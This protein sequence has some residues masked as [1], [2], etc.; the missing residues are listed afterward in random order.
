MAIKET[1]TTIRTYYSLM[2]KYYTESISNYNKEKSQLEDKLNNKY[3]SL[4]DNKQI[5]KD[6]FKIDLDKYEEFTKC[7][8]I[9]GSLHKLAKGLFINRNNNYELVSDLYDL[10]TFANIQKQIVEIDNNISFQQKLV[11]LTL[12]EYIEILRIFYTEVHKQMIMN[13]CGYSFS[14]SIGWICINR[15]KLNRNRPR[16]DYAKTKKREAELRAQG[17]RIYNKEEADWCLR[18]GI[19]YKAEDKRVFQDIEY[20]YEI[21]LIHSKLPNAS[22]IKFEISDYRHKDLRGKTNDNLI[23]LCNNSV[24]EICKLPIDLRTKL[25]IADK[26]NKILYTNFIR[27]EAQTSI[28]F[29]KAN[30]KD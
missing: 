7:V 11:N 13:G 10:F 20:V 22:K 15:I 19:E 8:Y 1:P 21:P 29:T 24:E 6:N 23:E 2:K 14:S 16:I 27:N 28:A 3:Q 18:N 25:N 12:K 17:K 30:S 4:K 9:N 26:T 5:F